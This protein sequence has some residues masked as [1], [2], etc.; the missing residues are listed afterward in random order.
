MSPVLWLALLAV[1]GA[2]QP[3]FSPLT[4]YISELGTRGSPNESLIRS[5]AFGLTGFLYVCFA[6]G[7]RATHRQGWLFAAACCLIAL[8]G[9]GR[10]G[11][12]VFPCDPGCV[13]ATETQ[14]LHTRFATVGFCSGILAALLWGA[15]L[16]S[17]FS[18]GCGVVALVSLL[19]MSWEGN[20]WGG[21]GLFEHLATIVLSIWLFVFAVRAIHHQ[22]AVAPDRFTSSA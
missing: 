1:G 5:A 20:P 8:E 4:H 16:R 18:V 19:L 2:L 15:L 22:S 7:L 12:G 9:I 3:G 17:R 6:L 11:A 13:R 21:P 14:D 10:M